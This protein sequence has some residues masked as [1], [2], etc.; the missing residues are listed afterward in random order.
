[1][2]VS[3]ECPVCGHCPVV[4]SAIL[5]N[6]AQLHHSHSSHS[7]TAAQLA[8]SDLS[9]IVIYKLANNQIKRNIGVSVP[10]CQGANTGMNE[11]NATIKNYINSMQ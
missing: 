2:S 8:A 6:S 10:M 7:T 4:D 5:R 9:V 1:M 11:R 3:R